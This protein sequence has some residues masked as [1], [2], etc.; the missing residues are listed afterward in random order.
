MLTYCGAQVALNPPI[1]PNFKNPASLTTLSDRSILDD[2]PKQVQVTIVSLL[3]QFEHAC[4][5]KGNVE[6]GG[7]AEVDIDMVTEPIT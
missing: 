3:V 7:G 1:G 2:R 5:K 4:R 6:A